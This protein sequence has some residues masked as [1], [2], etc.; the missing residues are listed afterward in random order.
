LKIIII[1]LSLMLLTACFHKTE[2]EKVVPEEHSSELTTENKEQKD[3]DKTMNEVK[4]EL[5]QYVEY[6]YGDM[7]VYHNEV[8]AIFNQSSSESDEVF[9]STVSNQIIPLYKNILEE[10]IEMEKEIEANDIK[11]THEIIILAVTTQLEAFKLYEQSYQL[12]NRAY[13]SYAESKLKEAHS[14][15]QNYDTRLNLL[16]NLYHVKHPIK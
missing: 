2:D 11:K 16:L 7:L 8:I 9:F 15:F 6:M 3:N 5:T 10:L 4:T 1:F 13:I 12:K 14:H